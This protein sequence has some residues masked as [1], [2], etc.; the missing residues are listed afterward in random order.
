MI[1]AKCTLPKMVLF[2][3]I[4]SVL[5]DRVALAQALPDTPAGKRMAQ[6]LQCINEPNADER[7]AFLK[8]GFTDEDSSAL[9][10]RTE[11]AAKLHRDFPLQ[12][13]VRLGQQSFQC[14]KHKSSTFL[15]MQT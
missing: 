14:A 2:F 9:D 3:F 7:A 4:S 13:S 8:N 15:S 11:E 10:E 5:Q 12:E 1:N 6:L